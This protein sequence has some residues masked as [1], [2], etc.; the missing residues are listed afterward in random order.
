MT[1]R[2]N[3]PDLQSFLPSQFLRARRPHLFSDSLVV[4]ESRLSREIFEYHLD[5]LTSRKE[6]NTFEHFCRCL[7]EKELCPNLIP[8]TGPTG[9]GDSKVD[10][11][12]YP[13][14]PAIRERW[15]EGLEDPGTNDRWAFAFSAKKEW[16]PKV[17]Q[18][19]AS[20]INTNRDYKRI[21][22]ITNQFVKD[23]QRGETE[24]ELTKKHGVDVRILDR[25]WI[26]RCVF[27][28]D[29]QSLAIETLGL[30]DYRR[31]EIVLTGPKDAERKLEL[32]ELEIRIADA[33]RYSGV[34]F[35]LAEDC[36]R[37]ALL[38]RGLG[39]A[40]AEVEGR[41]NRAERIAKRVGNRRQQL[42]IA[43]N[44]AWTFFFW[45]D[46]FEAFS[47][48]YRQTEGYACGNEQAS[49]L[50]L[51]SYLW[52]LLFSS[53]R[54]S[55][56]SAE[57]TSLEK[58]TATLKRELE[59]LSTDK[60][61]PTNSLRAYTTLLLIRITEAE[62][63]N[64]EI[65]QVLRDLKKV[66]KKAETLVE[67]PLDTL[68]GLVR[69][70]GAMFPESNEYDEL[71]EV[72]VEL[73]E[74][75]ASE[76]SAGRVLLERGYQKL[77]AGLLY[78]TISLLG[79]A[80]IKLALD[81]Y[82]DEHVK[83][84][85]G[86]GLAY[87]MT[88]L[89]W[90]GRANC[91]A[92]AHFALTDFKEEG[93]VTDT[94]LRCIQQLVWIELQLG[95]IPAV[96]A[97]LRLADAV[98]RHLFV[99]SESAEQYIKQRIDQDRILGLLLLLTDHWDLK[100]LDFLPSVLERMDLP[101]ARIALLYALGH[102]EQLRRE[103]WI[104]ADWEQKDVDELFNG[105]I[106]Q[107]ARK[108]LPRLADLM[109]RRQLTFRSYVLGCEI[110][111]ETPNNQT[112]VEVSEAVLSS[113]E[114]LLSTALD[115]RVFPHRSDFLIRIRPS[116]FVAEL[117]YTVEE[118]KGDFYIEIT[119]PV[120]MGT[121]PDTQH[122]F[123]RF[124]LEVVA[125]TVARIAF[126]TDSSFFEDLGRDQIG[127]G[128]ALNYASP[129][130]FL[131]NL[132][133]DKQCLQLGGWKGDAG[134]RRYPLIRPAPFCSSV[135][136]PKEEESLL[137]DWKPGEGEPPPGLFGVDHIRH[138]D[139]RVFSLINVPLWDRA[140]WHGTGFAFYPDLSV[141]P[142][143]ALLFTDKE[144]GKAIFSGLQTRLGKVDE[145]EQLRV[146]IITGTR[147]DH[148]ASYSVVVGINPRVPKKPGSQFV[149]VYRFNHMHPKDSK[150][151]DVFLN[152]FREERCYVLVPGFMTSPT[153]P[154][155]LF[156]KYGILKR[157]LRVSPAWK[158]TE[159]D[160]DVCVLDPDQT[161]VIPR[162]VKDPPVLRALQ[163]VADRRRRK[164]R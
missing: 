2:T 95:R 130:I 154:P 121:D 133:G 125:S 57:E 157:Q 132:L 65:T 46:D 106:T 155:E 160:P 16:R 144:A 105:W 122:E 38:A 77:R 135:G 20:I 34:E 126:V 150:N 92:A 152:K 21:Y 162:N 97:W 56:L 76:G 45:Y 24:S 80:Q 36:L 104:P 140:K 11:E 53:V 37:S 83:A 91:L 72:V 101:N 117:E 30:T 71:L 48:A 147:K 82:R 32:D 112:S 10:S 138:P 158:L 111:V 40:R 149:L 119:H 1:E 4:A 25:T 70:L 137:A 68:L 8:Q 43:Y 86:C 164:K 89:L 22:F 42:R 156:P 153:D 136:E 163:R 159:N 78:E 124:L 49:D 18:D 81:E 94:A 9:G 123:R 109:A 61:R 29:R 17:G 113:L 129:S 13:V 15:Y 50:E 102:E 118:K 33:D 145:E 73:A 12:T 108:E 7:S 120:T 67:F 69:E 142:I 134:E 14:A 90:A 27:E 62:G 58:H 96:L 127:F 52:T 84:L 5:T 148:S 107:P 116:D 131:G 103:E 35:Q 141:P 115:F 151:L 31:D 55:R 59:R 87:V 93:E 74:A 139:R 41:F 60:T 128:R 85:L 3:K 143:L 99:D 19:V 44:K 47:E 114:A 63:E 54:S 66:L 110:V 88:G 98:A 79:R 161:P 23:K 28:H 75:R 26:M 39:R 51:L 64:K 6:E 146:S 100:W